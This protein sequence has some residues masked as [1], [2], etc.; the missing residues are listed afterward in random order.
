MRE[1]VFCGSPKST[2]VKSSD[3]QRSNMTGTARV[4]SFLRKV[5]ESH[6]SQIHQAMFQ[7]VTRAAQ[8]QGISGRWLLDGN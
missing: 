3:E 2:Q 6:T 5:Q 7:K 8:V 4:S 1:K